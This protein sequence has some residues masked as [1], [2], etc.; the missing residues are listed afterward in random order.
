M[1]PISTVTVYCSS[2]RKVA[3]VY[4]DAA[5]DLGRSIARAGCN[6]VYGGN[7]CGLMGALAN[8]AREAGGRVIG[9]TPQILHDK[10]IS[11]LKCDELIVAPDMRQ[12]KALLEGRADAFIALPGGIGTFEEIFE[13]IV[14]RSLGIYAKPLVLLNIA[15]YYTPLLAF[16]QHS[17]NQGFIRDS[18]AELFHVAQSV[19]EAIAYLLPGMQDQQRQELTA[20]PEPSAVE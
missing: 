4:F 3:P 12:R 1:P 19:P 10:G 6:L 17:I 7:D 13:I 5:R 18:L 8:S 9:I 15:D 20:P 2:S 16:L 14:A 11:D